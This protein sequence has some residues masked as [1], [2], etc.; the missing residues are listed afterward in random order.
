MK[1]MIVAFVALLG[2]VFATQASA[3]VSYRDLNL[4]PSIVRTVTSNIGWSDAAD[5]DWGDSHHAAWY[6]FNLTQDSLVTITVSG[7][8]A[9]TYNT[10][11]GTG[12][13]TTVSSGAGLNLT[14][15]GFT[16][17]SG[18]FPASV[19]DSATALPVP[20]GKDGRWDALGDTTMA[21]NGANNGGVPQI[22]TVVFKT[23]VN[24]TTGA[25]E[26][27]AN[28]FLAAG[29]YSIGA[30]GALGATGTPIEALT[31]DHSGVYAIQAALSVQPVP[32]P[33]AIWLFGSALAGLVG[34]RRKVA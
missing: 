32:V 10:I 6:K 7:L 30:G 14:D 11:N 9:G 23:A 5:G 8:A 4:S 16:L 15:V 25:I 29:N 12:A 22:G 13:A 17:Y 2:L 19:Y 18:L 34:L 21:N 20:V 3:H 27:L 1:K 31:G 28:Y 26:T 24:S 33:G